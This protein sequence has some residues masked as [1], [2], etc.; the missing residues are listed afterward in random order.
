MSIFLILV[1]LPPFLIEIFSL[2]FPQQADD[3]NL[4]ARIPGLLTKETLFYNT[5]I[6]SLP[7]IGERSMLNPAANSYF[8]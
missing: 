2:N 6:R 5:T 4:N 1:K 7:L 8:S 3:T